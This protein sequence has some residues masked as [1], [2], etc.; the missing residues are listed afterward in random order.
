MN[1]RFTAEY[2]PM[3]YFVIKSQLFEL[4]LQ[5]AMTRIRHRLLCSE[6]GE[7]AEIT[8]LTLC[9]LTFELQSPNDEIDPRSSSSLG[10][11]ESYSLSYGNHAM[12]LCMDCLKIVNRLGHFRVN[13]ITM[14]QGGTVKVTS[15]APVIRL[16]DLSQ[17]ERGFFL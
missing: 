12:L 6:S 3:S 8:A 7:Y 5:I 17:C 16:H 10:I 14:N 1:S 15:F 9:L 13:T 4:S 2:A 11:A